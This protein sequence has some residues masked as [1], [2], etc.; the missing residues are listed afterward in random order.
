MVTRASF[1]AVDVLGDNTWSWEWGTSGVA[2]D[3]G[4]YTVYAVSQPNWAAD[5]AN[6]AYGTCSIILK[7][8]FVSAT[9]SQST[10]ANGD[11]IYITGTAQGQPALGVNIWIM[12]KNYAYVGSQSVNSDS[13]F[14]YEVEGATTSTLATGQYFVVVQHPME[15]GVFDVMAIPAP[16]DATGGLTSIVYNDNPSDPGDYSNLNNITEDFAL[17]RSELTPGIQCS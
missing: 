16:Q 10:V 1:Q 8:P 14:S 11:P 4:T 5:L 7:A 6:V 12:G 9:A 2:L 15:N 17:F 13:S 3:A